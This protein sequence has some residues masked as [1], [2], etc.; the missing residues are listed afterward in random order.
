MYIACKFDGYWWI[1]VVTEIDKINKEFLI[2]GMHPNGPSEQFYWPDT[3]DLFWVPL[4]SILLLLQ[5][6]V[7]IHNRN[8]TFSKEIKDKLKLL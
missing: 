5:S 8:F 7:E 4:D 3:Q 6:P 2:D 1:G